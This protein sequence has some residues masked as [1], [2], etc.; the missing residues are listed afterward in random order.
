MRDYFTEMYGADAFDDPRNWVNGQFK[1]RKRIARDRE[2]ASVP[3]Q[4]MDASPMQRGGFR[5]GYAFSDTSAPRSAQ[6]DAS[7]AYAERSQRL[8][9]AWRK[10]HQEAA[11]RKDHQDAADDD[12]PLPKQ[13]ARAVADRAW[14][15]KKER[16]QT[17]W[18]DR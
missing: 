18:R 4:V 5:R 10:D 14:L 16:L 9:N 3:M 12:A 17:S 8:E 6:E 7:D 2:G 15:D 13:D 1:P 11:E